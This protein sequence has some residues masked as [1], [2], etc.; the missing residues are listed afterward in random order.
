MMRPLYAEILV[1]GIIYK[2]QFSWYVGERDIWYLDYHIENLAAEFYPIQRKGIPVLD[3]RTA[4]KFLD[5]M[6]EN[7]YSTSRL[8]QLFWDDFIAYG[9]EAVYDY[10]PCFLVDFDHQRFYSNFP[11][12]SSFE[13]QIPSHWAGYFKEFSDLIPQEYHYWRTEHGVTYLDVN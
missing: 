4:D 1:A 7:R 8:K 3:E 13:E 11:E 9:T 6:K 12:L 2:G 10:R 5:K